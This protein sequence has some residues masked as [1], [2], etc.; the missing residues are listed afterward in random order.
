MKWFAKFRISAALD[1][2]KPLPPSLRNAIGQSSELQSFEKD[3]AALGRALEAAPPS[4][5]EPPPGLHQAIMRAVRSGASSHVPAREPLLRHWLPASAAA[6]MMLFAA[7]LAL[8]P[9]PDS[10]M[11][12]LT[13]AEALK[14]ALAVLEF[15]TRMTPRMS[16]E[17]VAP[18]AAEWERLSRDLDRTQEFLLAS[19][20]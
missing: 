8:R 12:S 14:P 1:S 13:Q 18:L 5:A 19:L 4:A 9:A 11:G 15:G 10:P 6:A 20:P 7:W 3:T 2:R 17:M 16:S